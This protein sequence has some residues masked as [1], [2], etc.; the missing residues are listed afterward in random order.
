MFSP[1]NVDGHLAAIAPIGVEQRAVP[2]CPKLRGG[3]GG[4]V[5][6]PDDLLVGWDGERNPRPVDVISPEQ[7]VGNDPAGRMNHGDNTLQWEPLV[8]LDV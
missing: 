4:V 5:S 7:V 1:L 6:H 2:E 8:P 3:L